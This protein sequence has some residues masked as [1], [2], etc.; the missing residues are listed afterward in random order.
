MDTLFKSS[1]LTEAVN[2]IKPVKT[3]ILDKV[4][5]AKKFLP[6]G[7]FQWDIISGSER[8]LKNLRLHESAQISGGVGRS[9][10]TCSGT[11]FADKRQITAAQ[12]A[13]MRKFGDRYLPELLANKINE[14][15][16]DMRGKIDRT[17]EFMAAK[18]LTGQVVDESGTVLVDYN[19]TAAQKPVLT[20]KAKWTDSE[21]KPIANLRAWK[22]Q[23][24]QAVGAVDGFLAFC[25]SEAMDALL[26]NPAVLELLKYQ[27][28]NQLADKGR[29]AFL[30]ETDIEE[31]LGSYIDQNNARQD[32]IAANQFVL[33]GISQQVAGEIYV[34]VV[35]LDDPNGVGSGN[36]A[37]MFFSK[38]W[39]EQD[40]SGR[41]VK[42]ESRPLPVL[43]K[44]E[45]IVIATVK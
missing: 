26:E 17:R 31:Y 28:G 12:L 19:F 27:S 6:A 3:T 25:G 34:P 13:D 21:S 16:L 20:G 8:I 29:I 14:E 35:D 24:I 18:A 9:T 40:P 37:S 33:V 11:R 42:V 1:V 41:W 32:M 15:L 30:A 23:I 22:K 4:F 39:V 38:S 7:M 5:A 45:A 43:Y 10:V 2:K 36:P 44:P